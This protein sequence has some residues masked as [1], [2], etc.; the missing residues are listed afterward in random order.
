M[1]P[2]PPAFDAQ[3]LSREAGCPDLAAC[4]QPSLGSQNVWLCLAAV[5]VVPALFVM[6]GM[7]VCPSPGLLS[8][9]MP[10]FS[11]LIWL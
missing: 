10:G 4:A 9:S 6:V 1:L 11:E 3:R 2:A 8:A 7:R 5:S